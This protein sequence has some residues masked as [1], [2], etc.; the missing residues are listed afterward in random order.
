MT[1][2]IWAG[3]LFAAALAGFAQATGPRV[4]DGGACTAT[5][6]LEASGLSLLMH[7]ASR[8]KKGPH[9][10]LPPTPPP[11]SACINTNECGQAS[12]AQN[13]NRSLQFGDRLVIS[14]TDR[15]T[16]NQ[17][18]EYGC[19]V[20]LMRST[21]ITP[22]KPIPPS[23]E[24][25]QTAQHTRGVHGTR[26]SKDD[27]SDHPPGDS[28]FGL[29]FDHGDSCQPQELGF[30]VRP[31]PDSDHSGCV[32]YGDSVVLAFTGDQGNSANCGWYGCRVAYMDD[33][34]KYMAFDHGGTSPQSFYLR[35]PAEPQ[36]SGCINYG[37]T[38][39]IAQ[40]ADAGSNQCGLYGCRVAYMADDQYLMFDHGSSHLEA[41]VFYVRPAL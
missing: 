35:A 7:G 40:T 33:A 10:Y 30:W 6:E 25:L 28:W 14:Q 41:Q 20:G 5:E 9:P 26:T 39:V 8:I 31:K 22:D 27:P 13:V 24:M 23:P 34:S 29:Y 2:S 4:C 38:V 3:S 1:Y 32:R 11:K 15:A 12:P 36:R 18:G 19:R 21:C 16:P 17:C 37:D